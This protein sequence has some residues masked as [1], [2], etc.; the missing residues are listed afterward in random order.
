MAIYDEIQRRLDMVQKEP[1]PLELT[2]NVYEN[3]GYAALGIDLIP[4]NS[5]F[6]ACGVAEFIY[7]YAS[8]LS[9]SK[10]PIPYDKSTFEYFERE[11]LPSIRKNLKQLRIDFYKKEGESLEGTFKNQ[12]RNREGGVWFAASGTV[13][14]IELV[15]ISKE[16]PTGLKLMVLGSIA[17][18]G[19][20]VALFGG[21]QL[22][23]ELNSPQCRQQLVTYA[24]HSRAQV[25]QSAKL[26]G[27][28]TLTHKQSLD[29]IDDTLAAGIAACGS[30]FKNLG[31]EF[32]GPHGYTVKVTAG[33]L[34]RGN[35]G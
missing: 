9:R 3:E 28:L 29:K 12:F 26:Q 35:A 6:F 7:S 10:E 23:E 21:V 4:L 1:T 22:I 14:R 27:Q 15:A 31:L 24:E 18:I 2:V 16:N 20:L 17:A 19:F 13:L 32:G 5:V 8:H 30:S 33:E 11:I 25:M 34:R